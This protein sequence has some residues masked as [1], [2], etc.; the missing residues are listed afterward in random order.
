MPGTILILAGAFFSGETLL[1]SSL[2]FSPVTLPFP[3]LWFSPSLS[4]LAVVLLQALQ[5]NERYYQ[6]HPCQ[7]L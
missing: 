4:N 7:I 2:S 3:H 6:K 5:H 1:S